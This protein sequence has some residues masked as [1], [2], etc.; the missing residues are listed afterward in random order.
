LDKKQNAFAGL[1]IL[2]LSLCIGVLFFS[3]LAFFV[4]RDGPFVPGDANLNRTFQGIAALLSVGA[5]IFGYRTFNKKLVSIRSSTNNGIQK[6]DEYRKTLIGWW[7]IIEAPAFFAIICF[8]MVG[9]YAF[10][11][12]A[13]FHFLLM[14]LFAPRKDNIILL[15]NLSSDEV[16]KLED[17]D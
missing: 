3:I 14:V 16:R 12:L 5:L 15:L 4:T 7:A 6:M 10:L 13:G 1:R 2:H 9:N 17:V 8:M 11:A